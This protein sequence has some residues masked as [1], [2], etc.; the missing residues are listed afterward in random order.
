MDDPEARGETLDTALKDLRRINRLLGGLTATDAVLDPV[1]RQRE[2]VRV[3]DVGTGTGDYLAHL[4]RRGERFGSQVDATGVDLNPETI[5]RGNS[6]LDETLSS[7]LRSRID[8][9]VADALNLPYGDSTFDVTHA[10]LFVH[11]FHGNEAV[12]LLREMD[13]VSRFG[14]VVNDLHR[15]S[16]SWAGI[17]ALSRALGMSPMVQHDGPISVKRGFTRQE[18]HAFA[19]SADIGTARVKWHWAFRWTL[20]TLPHEPAITAS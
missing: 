1:L 2:K 14:I 19:E 13:R 20:S 15:H 8:L 5:G 12:Q 17:W 11:H 18:L 9:E 10:A 6:W 16:L 7:R 4:V 3:L